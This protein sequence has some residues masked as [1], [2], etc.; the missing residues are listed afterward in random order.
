[1]LSGVFHRKA[2]D[3]SGLN[4]NLENILYIYKMFSKQP[5]SFY[6]LGIGLVM[7][8]SYVGNQYRQTFQDED[9]NEEYDMVKEYLLNDSP[10]YGKNRPKLWIHSK[11][12]VNARMWKNFMSRNTTNLNQPYLYLTVQSVIRHCADDFHVCLIDDDSFGKLIPSWDADLHTIPEPMKSRYRD[13]GMVQLLQLYGGMIVP[14]S[15]ICTRPLLEMYQTGIEGKKPFVVEKCKQCLRDPKINN[16]P[17]IPDIRMMGAAKNDPVLD[18]MLD[19]LKRRERDGHFSR[20]T[21]FLG[22]IDKWCIQQ[23]QEGKMTCIDGNAIG[24]K[25]RCGKPILLEDLMGEDYLD[26]DNSLLFGVFVPKED[27]LKRPKYSWF[28]ILPHEDV[29]QSRVILAKYLQAS[30]VD[31]E[32][33]EKARS[34]RIRTMIAI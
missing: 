10:L 5:L 3:K 13:M 9:R 30:V 31:E 1:M 11:Y 22:E 26:V 24:I 25:T 2:R 16:S 33:A 29:M 4:Y 12:E 27:L 15:F 23:V 32:E 28:S 7:L 17:F 20:E 18:E 21:D 8:A 14:N 6:V 34:E 19:V